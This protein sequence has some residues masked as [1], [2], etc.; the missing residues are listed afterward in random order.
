MKFPKRHI[1]VI[2]AVASGLVM[3]LMSGL[4]FMSFSGPKAPAC[5]FYGISA[6]MAGILFGLSCARL[7]ASPI[8]D[9][10]REF[11]ANV[12]HELR[13]PITSIKGFIETLLDGAKDNPED[14]ERFLQIVA[15]QSDRLSAI[16]EDLLTLSRLE[17][18]AETSG[19][20]LTQIKV[21]GVLQNALQV[22]ET[23]ALKR[24]VKLELRCG[25][26]LAGK[27]N[28]PLIEQAIVNLVNNA[29]NHSP[30]GSTVFVESKKDKG[31][32]VIHVRDNGT[33]IA[34]EHL[35][36]LFERFYRAD[37]ARSRS[38]GGTGLGLAIV[39][40]IVQLHRGKVHVESEPGKG[41]VFSI[42]LP[43]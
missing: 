22:C 2:A 40:H 36:R 17:N 15:R 35:P 1:L 14:A 19:I 39:K 16:T 28:A 32:P 30:E 26:H 25:E 13:T 41:S 29:V 4:L 6:V 18:D 7:T 12:S 5:T 24:N 38:I 34:P 31:K 10:R 9:L 23:N 42:Y 3:I 11:V 27:L 37:K 21:L 20:P 43:K 33:G 8:E